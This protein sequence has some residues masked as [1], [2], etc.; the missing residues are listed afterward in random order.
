MKFHLHPKTLQSLRRSLILAGV[1]SVL[2][3]CD[4]SA[5]PSPLVEK[6]LVVYNS[7]LPISRSLA[8]HYAQLRG[9]APE[10][11]L[12]LACSTEETITRA[13]FDRTLY[14]PI[15]RYLIEKKWLKRR[16]TTQQISGQEIKIQQATENSVWIIVLMHGL[17]LRI[18][19]DPTRKAEVTVGAPFM[20]NR[21][22]VDSE[23]STLP[24]EGLPKIG[25]NPNPYFSQK[26]LSSFNQS[27]ANLMILVCRLD[28]PDPE[29]VRRMMDDAVATEKTELTGRIYLDSRNIQDLSSGYRIGDQWIEAC[30]ALA[31]A[32]G[33]E[34]ELDQQ[35]AVVGADVTWDEAAFY[36]GWYDW[37]MGGPFLNP[38]FHFRKGAIAYHIHSFS[39]ETLRSKD[40][41]WAGPLLSKGA[42][43]TM[44]SV[45][46]PYLRLTPDMSIFMRALLN[47][48]TFAE[49]AY[50]SQSALSWTMTM[51]GDPLYRPFPR[52]V[53]DTYKNAQ[54]LNTSDK[55][56]ILLRLAR[57]ISKSQD[58]DPIKL[59]KISKL[60][61]Q[62]PSSA[63]FL[64][65]YGDLLC[66]LKAAP[67]LILATR[68]EVVR[69][70]ATKGAPNL[71]RNSFKLATFY[72]G[73]N[74][75]EK[76]MAVYEGLIVQMPQESLIYHV[77]QTAVAYAAKV[78]WQDLSPAMQQ[79]L[80]P[81]QPTTPAPLAP[82][83]TPLPTS[84]P[85]VIPESA[86][87]VIKPS[88][89]GGTFKPAVKP[90]T[91]N[92]KP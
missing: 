62:A 87:P 68:L 14:D 32:S 2:F 21:A 65:G 85:S 52:H 58:I 40:K 38:N 3:R 24:T 51:L 78:G 72:A 47:G 92:S 17:P 80:A 6:V 79:Y 86:L 29:T 50:Q 56:W 12:G 43:A 33:H 19:E 54:D 28:A 4:L 53:L 23:L 75:I 7:E 39:A 27:L 36:F 66:E 42:A 81:V 61:E 5:Q 88:V 16:T 45:Y 46:E 77:P 18:D 57:L 74:Q 15:N 83:E 60:A 31:Q 11:L 84:A 48:Y 41:N 8:E 35:E 73:Q 90:Q 63:I 64:E 82:T 22:S 1:F 55:E 67:E 26:S 91:L 49:A 69:L 37:N 9:I 76:A 20:F 30:A 34:Y 70:A 13:Q 71:I 59:E 10:R 89:D 25:F 44:G